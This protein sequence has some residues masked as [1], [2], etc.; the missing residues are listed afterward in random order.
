MHAGSR[1]RRRLGA[2]KVLWRIG[3]HEVEKKRRRGAV[4]TEELT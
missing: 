2:G 1:G 3:V 4:E